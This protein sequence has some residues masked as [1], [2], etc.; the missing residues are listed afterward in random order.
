MKTQVKVHR[1]EQ[2]FSCKMCT[3]TYV[4]RSNILKHER[5]A[6]NKFVCKLCKERFSD[7]RD[8]HLHK[9]FH[10]RGNKFACEI[11]DKTFISRRNVRRHQRVSHKTFTCKNCD[12]QFSD[13]RDF[14]AHRQTHEGETKFP[15]KYCEKTFTRKSN[16]KKHARITHKNFICEICK[17]QFTDKIKFH[18]H[19]N[20]HKYGESFACPF[21][22]MNLSRRANLENHLRTIHKIEQTIPVGSI[23][24]K[25]ESIPIKEENILIE[26]EN[27]LM[28]KQEESGM[29]EYMSLDE[30]NF[31]EL[32]EDNHL[33]EQKVLLDDGEIVTPVSIVEC[34]YKEDKFKNDDIIVGI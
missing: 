17:E 8:F 26:Q 19:K 32:K 18:S 29:K 25:E 13:E 12:E 11:C 34:K 3:K 31:D 6:H 2:L 28:V 22:N 15:C 1:G 16:A 21:C 30:E 23:P 4:N 33:N 14:E 27:P 7:K 24:I 10:M 5:L 9:E 20:F